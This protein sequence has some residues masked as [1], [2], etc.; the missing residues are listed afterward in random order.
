MF[1]PVIQAHSSDRR[2]Q[3]P[4]RGA[5]DERRDDLGERCAP[6]TAAPSVWTQ[7]RR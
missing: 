2:A 6:D 3:A 7:L 5:R 4:E 1:A